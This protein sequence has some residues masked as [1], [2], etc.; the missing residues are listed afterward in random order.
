M[1]EFEKVQLHFTVQSRTLVS[2]T[3]WTDFNGADLHAMETARSQMNIPATLV[4]LN[5]R[6]LMERGLPVE[7]GV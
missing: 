4:L 2:S 1:T 6:I 5:A 3:L 7:V